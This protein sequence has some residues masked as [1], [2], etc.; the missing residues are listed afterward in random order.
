[1]LGQ[2]DKVTETMCKIFAPTGVADQS[3]CSIIKHMERNTRA[4]LGD[5]SFICTANGIIDLAVFITY[6]L[7]I[8]GT[9]HI[10]AV[11]VL[12]ASDIE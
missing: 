8:E 4:N 9:G 5:C 7:K 10:G 11:T 6:R 12:D 1:M 2:T 3:S